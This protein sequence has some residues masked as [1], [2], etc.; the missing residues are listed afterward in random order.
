MNDPLAPIEDQL[1]GVRQAAGDAATTT[2]AII[3]AQEAMYRAFQER[4][5]PFEE[6]ALDFM[7][8]LHDAVRIMA[9]RQGL[10]VP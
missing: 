10:W 6:A 4:A 3:E 5:T 8:H 1:A 2:A 9:E 7:S